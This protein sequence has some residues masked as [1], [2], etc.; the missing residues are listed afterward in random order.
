MV[1][2]QIMEE[3]LA[4][5]TSEALLL[6]LANPPEQPNPG[7][8]RA[9]GVNS[10]S[11]DACANKIK[12]GQCYWRKCSFLYAL[13]DSGVLTNLLVAVRLLLLPQ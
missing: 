8:S 9:L 4:N 6:A 11:C 12:L 1:Q 10:L 5:E 7:C 2:A 13:S 3:H